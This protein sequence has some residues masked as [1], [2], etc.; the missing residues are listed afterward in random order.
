MLGKAGR[1]NVKSQMQ[2]RLPQNKIN[3]DLPIATR[4]NIIGTAEH[5]PNFNT[6]KFCIPHP[7]DRNAYI[8]RKPVK[9]V[10]Q[11]TKTGRI[12]PILGAVDRKI[13]P[14]ELAR[15]PPYYDFM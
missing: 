7:L 13:H 8:N 11:I 9:T 1:Q 14:T 5:N 15:L 6:P 3:N 12:S 4:A 2:G 10:N